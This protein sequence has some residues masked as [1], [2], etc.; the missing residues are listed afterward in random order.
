[1]DHKYAVV[2]SRANISNPDMYVVYKDLENILNI[3]MAGVADNRLQI[4]N[5]KT[6]K[7]KSDG[8]YVMKGE[9]GKKNK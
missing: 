9:K 2:P 1:M 8:V 6:L 3:S 4:L 7:K 5:P